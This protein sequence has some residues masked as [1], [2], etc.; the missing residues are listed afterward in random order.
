MFCSLTVI[1]NW[2]W[3]PALSEIVFTSKSVIVCEIMF[4]KSCWGVWVWIVNV[5]PPVRDTSLL[6]MSPVWM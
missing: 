4:S 3:L 5:V 2:I 6:I 1:I